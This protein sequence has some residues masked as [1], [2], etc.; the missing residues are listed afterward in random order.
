MFISQTPATSSP[1]L[2]DRRAVRIIGFP[3]LHD[4][5]TCEAS[6]EEGLEWPLRIS[7]LSS[8]GLGELGT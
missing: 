3:T 5:M 4:T 7:G 6:A 1:R 8:R 2:P